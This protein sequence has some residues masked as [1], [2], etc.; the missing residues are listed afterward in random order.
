MQI[1]TEWI[2]EFSGFD[3]TNEQM[4]NQLTMAGVECNFS[5][6]DPKKEILNVS[7]T[8]NR[9]DCFSVMGIC[10]ELSVLNNLNIKTFYE[11]NLTTHHQNEVS[12]D[13]ESPDDCPVFIT[14]IIHNVDINKKTP[15]WMIKRLEMS[16]YK[17]INIIVDITNYVMLENGQPLHAYDLSKVDS[18]I[19]VRRG[20]NNEKVTLLD[21]TIKKVNQEYLLITDT[22]KVLGIAGI[23]GGLNSGISSET[24]SIVLE[25]AYFKPET[26]MG[27]SRMLNLHTESGLRFERGVDPSIQEYAIDRATQ[28]INEYANGENGPVNIKKHDSSIPHKQPIM[29]RKERIHQIL[30][31]TIANYKVH[32]ILTKLDMEV[33]EQEYGYSGW[34]VTPPSFRFDINEECDL[35]EELA[36]IYGYQNI[37][38]KTDLREN[39]LHTE[40]KRSIRTNRIN[41]IMVSRGYCE[42]IN[43]SFISPSMST[44]TGT[45]LKTV[46]VQNPLSIEMSVMR[47]SLLPGLLQNLMY[48]LQRQHENI[49]LFE[50]AKIFNNNNKLNNEKDVIAGIT[51]GSTV[52]EQWGLEQNPIDFYDV[53]GDLELLFTSL[54]IKDHIS[55]KKGSHPMF[56]KG[57]NAKIEFNDS[58]IGHVGELNPEL[59]MDLDLPRNPILFEIDKEYLGLPNEESYKEHLYFPSSRRDISLLIKQNQEVSDI[60][61]TIQKLKISILKKIIIFDV[62]K[63]VNI[64]SGRI[65]VALG[66]IFQAKSRTLT[67]E[68]IDRYMTIIKRQIVSSSKVKIR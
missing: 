39:T 11:S 6:Q 10:R 35:I 2:R 66:L 30:G 48:N 29:L 52:E 57:K 14:R 60:F 7:L 34:L 32:E 17:S 63:G 44:M 46:D 15:D 5:D 8:P 45:N 25:S 50:S 33:A 21:E 37:D 38:E 18:R 40:S 58:A 59:T 12:I 13:I 47:T 4:V 43:Y 64:E 51:Y 16:G 28:L 49:K 36:R 1:P 41:N 53:K 68:E 24:K 55:F 67:D 23:M 31:I 9:A 3:A 54:M 20:F 27:R 62:Y 22:S 19:K 65:S 42:V 26:I 61:K 56:C